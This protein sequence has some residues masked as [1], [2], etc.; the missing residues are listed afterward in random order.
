MIDPRIE[1]RAALP[2]LAIASAVE[3]G[4]IPAVVDRAFP[5]LFGWLG[6]HGIAP[7]GPPLLRVN[8]IDPAGVPLAIESGVPVAPD[9]PGGDRVLAAELPA[10]RYA[11]AEFV[12]PY[13]KQGA[14]DLEDAAV[15]F[16]AW[17]ERQGLRV[18]RP[19]ERGTALAGSAQQFLVG[20]P[21]EP[22]FRRWRTLMLQLVDET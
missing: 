3:N 14:P 21:I 11:V 12:G 9:T 15:A 6:E 1:Q 18:G 19:T 7:A 17:V 22:D 20:P 16:S 8:E 4:D 10:G 2:Y 5:E 13:R